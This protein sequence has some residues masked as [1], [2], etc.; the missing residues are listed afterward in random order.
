MSGSTPPSTNGSPRLARRALLTAAAALAAVAAPV[1][2]VAAT[3]GDGPASRSEA[4]EAAEAPTTSFLAEEL[5]LVRAQLASGAVALALEAEAAEAVPVTTTTVAP[6]TTTTAPPPPPPTT[7][8][9]PPPPPPPPPAPS[10][11]GTGDPEDPASWDRLAQCES[12]GN[13]AI[14][15]GN[16]YYGGLQFSLSSWQ[17]VGGTGYPHEHSRETQIEMGKRLYHSGGGWNHWP[18]CTRSFGWR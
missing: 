16:G 12:G 5:E 1:G 9:P 13:W 8:P 15:T 18:A 2:L 7:A 11:P 14:N 4:V 10:G 3:A 6:T 17:A